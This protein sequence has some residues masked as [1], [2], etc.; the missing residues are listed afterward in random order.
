MRLKSVVS[1]RTSWSTL[2]ILLA[3]A[4]PACKSAPSS[5][6]VASAEDVP[7]SQAPQ[8]TTPLASPTVKAGEALLAKGDAEGARGKFQQALSENPEDARAA[9]G[10]GL[11]LE[12][13]NDLPGAEKAYRQAIQSDPNLAEAHNNL[14]LVL[15]DQDKSAEAI[16]ELEQAE[17]LDPRLA[18]ASANLALAYEDAD[19]PEDAKR[20]YARAAKLAPK[21]AMLL[22]NYGL[23][24]LGHGDQEGSVRVLRQALA[25]AAGDRASLLAIGNGMRRA[26]K[27]DEAVRA[28]HS[29]IEADDGKP[30]VALLSELALAQNAAGDGPGAKASLEQALTLDSRYA[31]AHYLLGSMLASDGDLRGASEHYQR[32]IA[33]D[34]NGELATKAK[35]KLDVIKQSKKK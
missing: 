17:R 25:A 19:R 3:L 1:K 31:T 8:R 26:G 4:S 6:T 7:E 34:P 2:S 10:L 16:A 33:L 15:R 29:A 14:G 12:T 18:S 13:L 30:T 28:L 35:Q 22:S 20:A 27:P 24:L 9:L 23:F 21:D 5:S 11:A 32:C